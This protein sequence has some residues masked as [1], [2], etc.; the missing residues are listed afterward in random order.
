MFFDDILIS[1]KNLDT[2][3]H[4]LEVT[5][6]ILRHH[7]LYAKLSKCRFGCSEIDYLGHNSFSWGDPTIEAFQNLKI[8]VTQAPVLASLIFSSPLS[9]NVMPAGWA[10]GLF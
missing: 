9:S 2:H 5:L 6:G 10:L 8:V 3:K 1:S 4:H 7:T